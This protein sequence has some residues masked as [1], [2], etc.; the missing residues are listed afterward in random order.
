MNKRLLWA[1]LLTLVLSFTIFCACSGNPENAG[2][3]T[4]EGGSDIVTMGESK[5]IGTTSSNDP[6]PDD[7]DHSGSGEEEQTTAS[8][9]QEGWTDDWSK[10]Y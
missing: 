5:S 8:K 9:D 7:P 1:V 2:G 6:D 10:L 3:K 4:D